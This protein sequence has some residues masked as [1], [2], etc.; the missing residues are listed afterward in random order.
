MFTPDSFSKTMPY[1]AID[2]TPSVQDGV[3][4]FSICNDIKYP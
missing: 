4:L 2:S 1:I 3:C